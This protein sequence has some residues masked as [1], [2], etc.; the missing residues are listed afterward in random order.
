MEKIELKEHLST[1]QSK[2]SS[3]EERDIRTVGGSGQKGQTHRKPNTFAAG[4]TLL[5][6][7]SAGSSVGRLPFCEFHRPSSERRLQNSLREEEREREKETTNGDREQIA[8]PPA[9]LRQALTLPLK[10]PR[11]LAS[12]RL[13]NVGFSASC[14]CVRHGNK[15]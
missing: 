15:Q 12:G 6:L 4:S 14:S 9:L 7:P 11:N 10:V 13:D 3:R 5:S 1:F 2:T 8:E